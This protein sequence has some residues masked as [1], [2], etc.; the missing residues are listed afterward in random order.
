MRFDPVFCLFSS[1]LSLLMV[2]SVTSVTDIPFSVNMTLRVVAKVKR[3]T[4]P[5]RWVSPTL[6]IELRI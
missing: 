5:L 6:M 1:L 2:L 3:F 4:F